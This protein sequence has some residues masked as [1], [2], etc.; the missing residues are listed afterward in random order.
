MQ[1]NIYGKK[2]EQKLERQENKMELNLRYNTSTPSDEIYIAHSYYRVWGFMV[3]ELGLR[4]A[5]LM[6]Y[7]L[8]YSY[9]RSGESFTGSR[10]YMSVWT[11]SAL[12]T[13]DAAVTSLLRKGLIAKGVSY[14]HGRRVPK[15]SIVPE[16][17]PPIDMHRGMLENCR[18]ERKTSAV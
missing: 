1:Y 18:Q 5:E 9:F 6:S 7:A 14:I 13:V 10:K 12:S 15:Y 3:T 17:L 2:N 4:G 16:A 8:I 11:G